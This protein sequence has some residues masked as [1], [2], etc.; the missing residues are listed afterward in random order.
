MLIIPMFF[1]V[2]LNFY[3][4]NSIS[5]NYQ[6]TNYKNKIKLKNKKKLK[7]I[8][9]NIFFML[10]YNNYYYTNYYYIYIINCITNSCNYT[11]LRIKSSKKK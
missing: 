4:R 5:N 10:W 9:N 7:I 6:N 2:N 1:A 11:N 3:S 8:L